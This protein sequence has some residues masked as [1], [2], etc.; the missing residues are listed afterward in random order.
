LELTS[1]DLPYGTDEF[2]L[3]GLTPLPGEVVAAPRVAEAPISLECTTRQLLPLGEAGSTLLLAEV[4]LLHIRDTLIDNHG[5]A[6]PHRFNVLARMG[7]GRYASLGD[8]FK[9]PREE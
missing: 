5:C 8:I 7:G 9:L 4:K 6:D 2:T 3:A 1:G